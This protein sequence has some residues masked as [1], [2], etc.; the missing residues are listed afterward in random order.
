MKNY[1]IYDD[2]NNLLSFGRCSTSKFE[3][4]KKKG[5]ENVTSLIIK[6]EIEEA[7]PKKNRKEFLPALISREQWEE[8]LQRLSKL[9]SRT[10]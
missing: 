10:T 8:V 3:E 7:F 2:D 4:M 9:E 1:V 6:E 5:E